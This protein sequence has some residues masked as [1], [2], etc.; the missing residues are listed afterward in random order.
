MAQTGCGVRVAVADP[1]SCYRSGLCEVL[2]EAGFAPEAPEDLHEWLRHPAQRT[3]ILS[4]SLPEDSEH[5]QALRAARPDVRLVGLCT[6]PSLS[7]YTQFVLLGGLALLVRTTPPVVTVAALHVA[8][9]G[10]TV[11]PISAVRTLAE[12][13][14]SLPAPPL[15]ESETGWL[16]ALVSGKT[17]AGLAWDA[18]YSE[19]EMYRQLAKLYRRLGAA[20]RS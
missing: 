11:A 2:A 19:R 17:V 14:Q 12:R 20:N 16:R 1:L 9:A 4:L 15:T 3:V 13:G 6:A 8:L 7:Y 18:G 10:H 5:V